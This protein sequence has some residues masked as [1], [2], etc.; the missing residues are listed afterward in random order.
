MQGLRGGLN[1][2]HLLSLN[3][4]NA[5]KTRHVLSPREKASCDSAPFNRESIMIQTHH[6]MKLTSHC[7]KS[8]CSAQLSHTEKYS[9]Y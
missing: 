1:S 9:M 7:N 5:L 4:N 6:G 2:S 3:P 8:Q